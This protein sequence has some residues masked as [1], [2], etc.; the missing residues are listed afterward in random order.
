MR[1]KHKIKYQ[2]H[3]SQIIQAI[4]FLPKTTTPLANTAT[5]NELYQNKNRKLFSTF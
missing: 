1:P 5:G 4:I 2:S 3:T